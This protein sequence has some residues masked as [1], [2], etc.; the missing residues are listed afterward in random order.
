MNKKDDIQLL[1]INYLRGPNVWTYRA[2]LETWL[3]LGELED[4]PSNTLP[5]ANQRLCAWLPALM[6]HHCGVGERGG[7]LQRLE[8]GT[9]CGHVLEHVVIE[10]LNLAGMPTGFGQTRSTSR[11]GVY[12]MVFRARDEQVARTALA[13]GHRLLMCAINN[14]PFDVQAAVAAVREKLDDC[15][16][17]PSTAAIVAAATER[18]IPHIR[19]ND[20]NLVQL[21]HGKRQRRIWTA[22]TDLTSAIAEGIASEKDLTKSLLKA[23]GVPVPEGTVVAS[24]AEA[25][26]AAQDIGLP[27]VV[28]PT[29]GNHGRGVT[30]DLSTQA[31]IEAAWAVADRH[32]SEVIVER[33]VR[34]DEH[35]ML[36]VG[37]KVVAAARGETAWVTADGR[38]NVAELV[39][40]QINSDPRRGLTEDHP[41]NRLDPREDGVILLDLQRQ[42]LTPDSVPA[43][44]KRVLI[45]RNGNV[46]IDCTDAVHPE[47]AHQVSLAARTV[48][49]DVAGVDVVAED[50]SKPL[51]VQ[52]GA[53]VEVNAGPGLLMHLR[54][55]EGA[56]QPVGRAI[57]DH[58]FPDP[59][60][61]G[62]IPIVGVAGTRQTAQ[63]A[64]LVAWV[65]H[66]SGRHVGLA[67]RDGLFLDRR[68]V[69]ASDCTRWEAGRRLLIN[70]SVEAAVFENDAAAILRDGLAYDRCTVGI[71]TDLDGAET[72]EHYDVR[73]SDQLV[74]VL[75]TQVDVVLSDGV[76]VLNAADERIADLADLCDGSVILYAL[77]ERLP[78]LAEQLAAGGRAV[79][80]R[81]HRCVLAEGSSETLLPRLNPFAA[82]TEPPSAPAA[83][84]LLAAVAAAWA[85]GITADLITAG[86]QT[87][88]PALLPARPAELRAP[89]ERLES[90]VR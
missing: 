73:E 59:D 82:H 28:K 43:A 33:H 20:G 25:W 12:R 71:V 53:V 19:L 62:R 16:L 75:R 1:R 67:C 26:E 5:G 79:F 38:G 27:V 31:E 90:E 32:G 36:V 15:Y 6:E 85:M 86:I 61:S 24:P 46:A 4:H 87:F 84:A 35:R 83:E 13:Q 47:V 17:G 50:I 63:I 39:D 23:V 11:R 76:A 64:R 34:G 60:D 9:W 81:D 89:L 40:A 55:A 80:L 70:R 77:D 7:F 10:L 29:D 14:E 37:G 44:G 57:V 68:Q 41:L 72:L 56:P 58:L 54:P 21:G 52:G 69:E 65:M 18:R 42:G 8:E 22:E 45:Q 30:L 66:L 74:K 49:L 78:A 2:V 51:S 3:D 48:G 88:E